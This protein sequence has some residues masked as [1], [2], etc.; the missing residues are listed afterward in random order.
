MPAG[1][2]RAAAAAILMGPLLLAQGLW[3]RRVTPKLP[4][5]P[6]AREG[7]RAPAVATV[8]TVATAATARPVGRSGAVGRRAAPAHRR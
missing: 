7:V 6:G 5:A 8:A 2:P 4:E 3:V 1:K